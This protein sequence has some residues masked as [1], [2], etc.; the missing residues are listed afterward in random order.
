MKILGLSSLCTAMLDV[1]IKQKT[2][3][4]RWSSRVG[5]TGGET[6]K[7]TKTWRGIIYLDQTESAMNVGHQRIDV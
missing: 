3:N 1:A 4:M 2:S 5:L 7:H 6:Q